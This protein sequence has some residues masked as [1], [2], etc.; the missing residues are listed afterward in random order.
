[1]TR[2]S[3]HIRCSTCFPPEH[4]DRLSG[5]ANHTFD[6]TD[7]SVYE[8]A[9]EQNHTTFILLQQCK[10][11]ILFQI[12]AQALI[13]GYYRE[14]VTTCAASLER[15]YE[16]FFRAIYIHSNVELDAFSS[17]WKNMSR[18]SERQLGAY[19]AAYTLH[20][21]RPPNLLST[22][23]VEFRNAAVHRGELPT[24]KRAIEFA[25]RIL[26]LLR[27]G[28]EEMREA[29]P[30]AVQAITADHVSSAH[31][32][33]VARASELNGNTLTSTVCMST[34]VS[35]AYIDRPEPSVAQI[36]SEPRQ[37]GLRPSR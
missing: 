31:R 27:S 10:F 19:I 11:E 14:A 28:V 13:D 22:N 17:A 29:F 3:L 2:L 12:A 21:R 36:L 16:F 25:Q 37:H 30:E 35:L 34:I 26:D 5:F 8:F 20:F 7:S 1:M 4:S 33:A 15:F 23:D 9:C 32:F 6:Y 18:Q 24:R